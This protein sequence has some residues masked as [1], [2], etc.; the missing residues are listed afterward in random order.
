[1]G[2]NGLLFVAENQL[3]SASCVVDNPQLLVGAGDSCCAGLTVSL[4]TDADSTVEAVVRAAA[5]A[6]AHIAGTDFSQLQK[7]TKDLIPSV[8]VRSLG[9]L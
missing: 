8:E 1:M 6:A 5:V 4:A 7:V 9:A 3:Y 2:E